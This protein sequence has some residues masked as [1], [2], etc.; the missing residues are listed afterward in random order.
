VSERKKDFDL[1][2]KNT[3]NEPE[4][5]NQKTGKLAVREEFG[6]KWRI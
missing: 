4:S 3:L 5:W 2:N 1:L 6:R